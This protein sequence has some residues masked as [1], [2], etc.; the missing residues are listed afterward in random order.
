MSTGITPN[1][2]RFLSNPIALAVVVWLVLVAAAAV[3]GAVMSLFTGNARETPTFNGLSYALFSAKEFA[4]FGA[5]LA[6]PVALIVLVVALL[7][8]R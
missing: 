6:T 4:M 1:R 3:F 2:L 5:I 7:R 8:R